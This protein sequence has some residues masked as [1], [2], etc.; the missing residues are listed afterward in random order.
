M[1]N[2]SL[3]YHTTPSLIIVLIIWSWFSSLCP[4]YTPCLAPA[5]SL[6]G[7][8]CIV[9][10]C[11]G[12]SL[13]CCDH[14]F[15]VIEDEICISMRFVVVYSYSTVQIQEYLVVSPHFGIS[16]R[17]FLPF[18][19]KTHRPV[20]VLSV[21]CF[22]KFYD[23]FVSVSGVDVCRSGAW[24]NVCQM[25][26]ATAFWR[27]WHHKVIADRIAICSFPFEVFALFFVSKKH[28]EKWRKSLIVVVCAAIKQNVRFSQMS[29]SLEFI[30]WSCLHWG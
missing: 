14:L 3:I 4:R 17:L 15:V 2:I 16:L 28:S 26:Y 20:F 5:T 19:L 18:L 1:R 13:S 8:G 22:T 12:I 29:F 23:F 25:G 11:C 9:C 21:F 27:V 10:R 24:L 6:G 30:L 7:E